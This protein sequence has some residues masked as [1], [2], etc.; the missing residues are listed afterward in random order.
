MKQET[1][2]KETKKT[3]TTKVATKK[4]AAKET[5]KTT[6][7]KAETKTTENKKKRNSAPKVKQ[8]TNEELRVL[9]VKA[10]LSAGSKAKSENVVYQQFGTQSRVLQQSRGY[11][12]LLTNGHKK[13]KENVVDSDNDDVARFK[14]FYGKL[15][16]DEQGMVTGYDTI[17][18]AKLSES[19]MPRER[20]VKLGSFELLEKFLTFMAGFEENK[21]PVATK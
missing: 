14:T 17:E 9:F 19:E 12:L 8:M 5:V 21:I 7:V 4:V 13:V 2:K 16:K 10:G 1:N 3:N 18:T 11:Q 20:S 6:A 15:S